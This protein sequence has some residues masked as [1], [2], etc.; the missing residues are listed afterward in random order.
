MKE[1]GDAAFMVK[2]ESCW[3]EID[4]T[5]LTIAERCVYRTRR[6]A[7]ELYLSGSNEKD[8][9]R[10]TGLSHTAVVRL[11]NRCCEKDPETG[12][13]CGFQALVPKSKIKK[14]IR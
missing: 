4:E 14:F 10:T 3:E 8:I 13:Y 2:Q 7:L 6:R 5:K 1:R 11:W 12:E 9:F